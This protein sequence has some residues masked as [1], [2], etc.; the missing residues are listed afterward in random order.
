VPFLDKVI[1]DVNQHYN[2]RMNIK[3]WKFIKLYVFASW[4]FLT[5]FAAIFLLF[6]MSL[7]VFCSF[8]KCNRRSQVSVT[9]WITWG[10]IY[11]CLAQYFNVLCFKRNNNR[12]IFSSDKFSHC[13]KN[14]EFIFQ[15]KM[16]LDNRLCSTGQ[17]I[18]LAAILFLYW[19]SHRYRPFD[20]WMPLSL[21]NF[22]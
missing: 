6:L 8:Y 3:V 20:V 1:E 16:H 17:C 14:Q 19:S 15:W 4:K 11:F 18:F 7:Q 10:I 5:F 22:V 2:G 9:K 12:K 13:L 21:V